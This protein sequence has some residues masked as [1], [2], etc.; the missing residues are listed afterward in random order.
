M[1]DWLVQPYSL[2]FMR[3][4]A[5]VA[6][7]VGVVAPMVGVWVA[8]RRMTYLGDAMSHGTLGGVALAFLAGVD[9]VVGALAAGL[10]MAGGIWALRRQPAIAVDGAIGI[11]SVT[12]F[13]LGVLLIS[14][15]RFGVDISHFLFGQI[16][17]VTRP[18]LLLTLVI[19]AVAVGLVLVCFRDL[20]LSTFDPVHAR[21][22]GVRVGLL[23]VVMLI[24]VT[25]T[26]TV[27]LR[28]V[29]LLMAI[30]MLVVPANTA[31]LLGRTT[32][33]ITVI[34]AVLGVVASLGG[35]TLSYHLATPPGATIA[36]STVALLVVGAAVGRGDRL[37]QALVRL[38]SR[39]RPPGQPEGAVL[40]GSGRRRRPR[41]R[42]GPSW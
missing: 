24:L 3:E 14:A 22:V 17:A 23:D 16:A 20:E 28:T 21:Q 4:A 30:A 42:E 2:T 1:I 5:V 40:I 18:Q 6:V 11:S 34:A 7:V 15:G 26:V 36:L 38:H 13:A 41:V 31:R 12:L 37:R 33:G 27:C 9:V 25:L 29:G 8:L 19:G 35:L 39:T 10:L 32:T